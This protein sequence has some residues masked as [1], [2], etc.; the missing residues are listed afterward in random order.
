MD[1]KKTHLRPIDRAPCA[2]SEPEEPLARAER[3]VA[4]G[5]HRLAV[6]VSVIAKLQRLAADTTE[7]RAL[8]DSMLGTQ[9]TLRN[10]LHTLRKVMEERA[11]LERWRE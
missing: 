9:E 7:A 1:L 3:H 10:N 11:K 6:Q 2:K 8:L 5:A 4:D